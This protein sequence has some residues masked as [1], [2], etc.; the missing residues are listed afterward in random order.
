M[1]SRR[2]NAGIAGLTASVSLALVAGLTGAGPVTA[3]VPPGEVTAQTRPAGGPAHQVTLITGDRVR[4]DAKGRMAGFEA[5]RGRADVPVRT[6][7]EG[8]RTF[9]VPRDAQRLVAEGKLDRRLFDVTELSRA[10]SRE[11][12]RDGLRLIVA[13]G[14]DAGASARGAVREA[15]ETELNRSL[16]ALNADAVTT[17]VKSTPELWETLTR[18]TNGQ[19]RTTASGISRVWLDGLHRATLETSTG[20]IGAPKAW[21]TGYEG[22]GVRIAVL[23]TGVDET[24]PDLQGRV[25]AARNFSGAPD[26]ADRD[27]HGTHVA[28]T[29][30]GSGAGSNG[31]HRGVAPKAGVIN[32]KVLDDEG[33]GS[34]S[35]IIAGIDW[36]VA[37]GADIVN[38][39]LGREDTSGIDPLEAQVNKVTAE[40]GVLF[41]VAAGNS[42]PNSIG[43]PG[44]A[45]EAFTVGAVDRADKLADFSST[46]PR[47]RGGAVKPD[48]TAPG[49]DIDAAAPGG[50]R[51][52]ISGTSMAAPHVAGAAALLKQRHPGW[53][54]AEL[55]SALASSA[56][57]GGY[58]PHEQG[59]GRIAVDRAITQSVVGQETS[60]AFGKLLWPHTD[61]QPVTK[62]ITYRNSGTADVPLGL[63][64]TSHGPGGK[65][66]PA[67]FF[68]L[69][70]DR[71][72]VP[73]GG[74]ATVGLT[75]DSRLGGD[76]HGHYAAT[77][78]A[79][80]DNQTIRTTA[81][82]ELEAESY[83]ITLKH[84]GRDG[85]PSK[86]FESSLSSLTDGPGMILSG[87]PETV[88]RLPK[89][90]YALDA[91]APIDPAADPTGRTKGFDLVI[92]PKL[93]VDRTM[94]V[95]VDARKAKPA[96]LTL[97]DVKAKF[98]GGQ[99]EY[100]QTAPDRQDTRG[101]RFPMR[102][103]GGLNIAHL[104]PQVTDGTLHQQWH[105][106]WIKDAR[107][108][109]HGTSGGPVTRIATGYKRT[110][111][112]AEFAEVR[113]GLA[114]SAKDKQGLLQAYGVLP[115]T[116]FGFGGA[117]AT[118]KIPA[119][120]TLHLSTGDRAKWQL[121]LTQT[122]AGTPADD[123]EP[124]VRH[125]SE[126][127]S[128]PK[129]KVHRETLGTAAVAPKAGSASG[130]WRYGEML[131]PDVPMFADGQGNTGTSQFASA[132]TTLYRNGTKVAEN[133]DP[134]TG[135]EGLQ[136][137]REGGDFLL[138]TSVRRSPSTALVS[139]RI[140]SAWA[141]R[142]N[143]APTD[144][145]L[146][147]PV[148]TVRFTGVRSGLTGT[149]P[150]GAGQT[151]PLEVHGAAKDKVKS[152]T[153]RVSYDGGKTWKKLR[154][155]KNKVTLK[156]PAKGKGITLRAQVVDKQGGSHK[157]TVY[158]AFF[159]K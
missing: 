94:T 22:E 55:K 56:K 100:V 27:G 43:S 119:A 72:T 57:D 44:S 88:Q 73:A 38:L 32:A 20:Q 159:G 19:T 144:G 157:V 11:A 66:V 117:P 106:N 60:I 46:G 47:I 13:Y 155:T 99:M 48:V 79:T 102:S 133:S 122:P 113:V 78:E 50:G 74:T 76:T 145:E 98:T 5:G 39:S 37:Q 2:Q 65:P 68:T 85:K 140:D 70:A 89:G 120:H 111:N 84:I 4:V 80:G 33:G 23:D 105:A 29:A 114:A 24:H 147:L 121:A 143:A 12:Y 83:D 95:T 150:A 7:T 129:G 154:V 35:G 8:G 110:F 69:A 16:K 107:S 123:P 127:A 139:S 81:A 82:V 134:V 130:F 17:A 64:V 125:Y 158:N 108:E 142:A 116:L 34:D 149:A 31:T 58:T 148:S 109:Y 6:F 61:D 138:T 63:K 96:K 26:A 59:A 101:V 18:G 14:G 91:S 152:L 115:S 45:D 137:G 25:V 54:A 3:S 40:K 86:H 128:Y 10:E 124:E 1:F 77:V 87:T 135:Q 90:G 75:A 112:A 28:S 51:R 131:Y 141:F 62:K 97:S 156:N 41:A 36:A 42:G 9:V 92:Q 126:P 103:P 67:G 104:G 132:T 146:R 153:A 52:T 151:I 53:K 118:R 49:V 136:I 71:I 93:A 15:G 30:A 21:E